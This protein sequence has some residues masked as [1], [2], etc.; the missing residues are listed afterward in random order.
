MEKTIIKGGVRGLVTLAMLMSLSFILGKFLQIP[1]GDSIRI[2]FENLPILLAG[3]IY[4][5]VAGMITGVL[6]DLL[7]CFLKGY[8]IIP[9]ITIAAGVIGFLA[10]LM[11]RLIRGNSYI[12]IL[13]IALVPHITGSMIIKSIALN[14]AY[15]QPWAIL[16]IRIPIYIVTA[17]AEAFLIYTIYRKN[18]MKHL[19]GKF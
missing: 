4:G 18:L 13:L 17:A 2:S 1:I 14:L 8:A 12:S 7:G 5:P 6:A 16:A 10:G 9:L 15:G 11:R 3:I 19:G